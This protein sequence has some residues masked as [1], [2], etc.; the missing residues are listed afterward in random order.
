MATLSARLERLEILAT[1]TEPLLI[2]F[3]VQRAGTEATDT[4]TGIRFDDGRTLQRQPGESLDA[5][6]GRAKAMITGGGVVVL[7]CFYG[8]P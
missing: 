2:L 1:P 3:L 5:L 4:V 7:R 6:Q 8:F